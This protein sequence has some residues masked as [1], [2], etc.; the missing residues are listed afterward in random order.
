[1]KIEL[2]FGQI[3]ELINSIDDKE[4]LSIVVK[5]AIKRKNILTAQK[6]G[7]FYPGDKV[8][9][10]NNGK[11]VLG[12]IVK[13]NRKRAVIQAKNNMIWS[14]HLSNITLLKKAA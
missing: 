4:T 3:M 12:I 14:V 13:E 1:M 5:K 2:S 8:S 10:V 7:G 11:T 6:R 9:F